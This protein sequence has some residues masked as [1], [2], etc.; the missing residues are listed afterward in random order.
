MSDTNVSE[1]TNSSGLQLMKSMYRY[2]RSYGSSLARI[3][4]LILAVV[5]FILVIRWGIAYYLIIFHIL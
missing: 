4:E 1:D 2:V 3:L 5:L